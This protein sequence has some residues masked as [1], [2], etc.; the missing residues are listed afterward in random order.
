M[1]KNGR[2]KIARIAPTRNCH[3]MFGLSVKQEVGT[4]THICSVSYCILIVEK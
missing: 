2:P 1:I 4:Y 3:S